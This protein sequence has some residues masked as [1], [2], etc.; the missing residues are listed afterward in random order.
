VI[1]DEVINI[2]IAG[3]KQGYCRKTSDFNPY[4]KSDLYPNYLRLPVGDYYYTDQY[5]GFLTAVPN[6]SVERQQEH[7]SGI[8]TIT[9]GLKAARRFPTPNRI[10]FSKKCGSSICR[11]WKNHLN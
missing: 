11:P 10:P 5:R 3:R 9:D 4:T 2:L 6:T 1:L 7:P 8:A